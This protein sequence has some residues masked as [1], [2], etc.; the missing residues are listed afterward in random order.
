MLSAD[1]NLALAASPE[2]YDKQVNILDH[3]GY[4]RVAFRL[5]YWHLA[6]TADWQAAQSS[7]AS[8]DVSPTTARSHEL[9]R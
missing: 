3:Q 5:A 4:V 2:L 8:P 7:P 9:S 6:H 1:L